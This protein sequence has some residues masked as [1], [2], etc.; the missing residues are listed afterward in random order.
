MAE[1][2]QLLRNQVQ[3]QDGRVELYWLPEV[4][5]KSIEEEEEEEGVAAEPSTFWLTKSELP[6][7]IRIALNFFRVCA[8]S[9]REGE[10]SLGL[11]HKWRLHTVHLL[12]LF[13]RLQPFLFPPE[14][15]QHL[16]CPATQRC[17]GTIRQ[18]S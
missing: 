13:C 16:R 2:T 12:F 11:Q 18:S 3:R 4:A 9:Q 15:A 5:E 14:I 8:V 6:V 17:E 10:V 1:R 7:S